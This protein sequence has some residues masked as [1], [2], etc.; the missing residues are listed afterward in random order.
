MD[1]RQGVGQA[2]SEPRRAC[3]PLPPVSNCLVMIKYMDL[4]RESREA[5]TIIHEAATQLDFAI[6]HEINVRLGK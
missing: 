2:P 3:T 6:D 5:Q 1:N 4:L